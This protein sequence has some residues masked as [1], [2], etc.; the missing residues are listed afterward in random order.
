MRTRWVA[1]VVAGIALGLGAV[2]AI[3]AATEDAS[4][5]SGFTVSAGQLQIN[6]KIS[7]A[8]VRRSNRSLN[9]LAPIRTAQTDAADSGNNGVRPLAQITGS[10]QGWTT[11]QIANAAITTAKVAAAAV[12]T[13]KLADAAVT[14]AKLAAA[15]ANRLPKWAVVNTDGTLLRGTTGV[16]SLRINAGNYRVDFGRD[17]SQCSWTGVQVEFTESEVGDIGIELDV[18]D[19]ANE[20]L[21]VRTNDQADASADRVFSVQVAC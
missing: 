21:A 8:A 16:A 3:E 14:E 10:G 2:L 7:Q 1:G 5:Q 13:P 4:A 17:I 6:Q 18:L 9:Y 19:A 20:T 12:T 15:L 11:S